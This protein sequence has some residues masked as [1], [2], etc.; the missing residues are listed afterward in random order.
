MMHYADEVQT[1]LNDG[2]TARAIEWLRKAIDKNLKDDRAW[3]MLGNAYCKLHDWR[4]AMESYM[5]AIACNPE[6]PAAE[7]L[8][9]VESIVKFYNKDVYGQ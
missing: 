5:E 7:S 9:M 3:Y 6:S 1:L 4:S 2:H 8:K